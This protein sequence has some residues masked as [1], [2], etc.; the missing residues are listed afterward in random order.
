MFWQV[1]GFLADWP[2][3]FVWGVLTTASVCRL[4]PLVES[5]W[6]GVAVV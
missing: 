2:G 5:V 6:C 4:V 1:G 3:V